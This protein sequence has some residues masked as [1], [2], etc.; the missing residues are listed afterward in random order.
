MSNVRLVLTDLDGTA[1]YPETHQPS[2]VVMTAIHDGEAA[3]IRFC[4]VTG[5]PFWMAKDLLKAMG[6]R[7]PCI[8]DGGA[9]IANPESGEILWSKQLPVATAKMAIEILLPHVFLIQYGQ[10]AKTPEQ[11]D[12]TSIVEPVRTVW[13]SIPKEKADELLEG[14]AKLPEVAVHANPSPGGDTTKYGIQVTHFEADKEFAV[15]EL[16]S[17]LH[18]DK[19]HTLAIGDGNNDLPLFH[20]AAVK[21]AMGNATD[22]LKTEADHIVS[23][24]Q[25][26]GFAEAI[27]QFV[28]N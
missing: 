22:L 24:V 26:D 5:R 17:I 27:R 12:V 14:L 11:V 10:G 7:D 21:V 18:V 4:A 6:F 2:E 15:R 1:V 9:C 25:E 16:L 23:T 20:G 19:E 28:L 13:C 8:F 3:G